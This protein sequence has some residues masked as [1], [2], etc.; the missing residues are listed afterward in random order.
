MV[1]ITGGEFRS[2]SLQTPRGAH[3]RPSHAQLRQALFNSIQD[4]IAGSRCLDLFA[5]AGTLGFE[6]LSRG[7]AHV[8]AFETHVEALHCIRANAKA[9]EIGEPLKIFDRDVSKAWSLMAAQGPWDLIFA[10]PPYHLGWA[11]RMLELGPWDQILAPQGLL[12]LQWFE[13]NQVLPDRL[14]KLEKVREKHYGDSVLTH[15]GVF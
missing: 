8:A 15:Y 6:A 11:M 14:G 7:A 1:R 2:R 13:K 9:L 10:D 5:G 12:I 4:R 3:T